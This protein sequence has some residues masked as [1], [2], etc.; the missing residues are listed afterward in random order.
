MNETRIVDLRTQVGWTQERL[1]DES[2]VTV[3]TVRRLEA[4][5]DG[6]LDTLSRVAKAFGVPVHGLFV[7]VA[8]DDYGVGVLLTIAVVVAVATDVVPNV[9][10]FS[11]PAYWVAGW[12]LSMFLFLVVLS[13]RLDRAYPLSRAATDEVASRQTQRQMPIAGRAGSDTSEAR[14]GPCLCA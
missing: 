10:V 5:N 7:T 11:I 14:R 2:G 9:A 8:E 13:P 12:L 1:A 3:R 4:G 6:S